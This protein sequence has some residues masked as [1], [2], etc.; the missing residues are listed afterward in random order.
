MRVKRQIP[1]RLPNKISKEKNSGEETPQ[2]TMPK[3]IKPWGSKR[4]QES[5]DQSERPR[6]KP[7]EDPNAV[8]SGLQKLRQKEEPARGSSRK[9]SKLLALVRLKKCLYCFLAMV[10]L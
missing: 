6:E 10:V 4:I 5:K 2:D 8:P 9:K 7:M 3:K 1:K